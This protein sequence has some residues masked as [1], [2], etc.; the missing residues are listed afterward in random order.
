MG[1]WKR[2]SERTRQTFG[3]KGDSADWKP[4]SNAR[5]EAM[6]EEARKFS[7][8]LKLMHREFK[9]LEAKFSGGLQVIRT[10]LSS[11]LPRVYEMTDKGPVPMQREAMIVGAGVA[12]D[13]LLAAGTDL[14]T[15]LQQ[16]VLH[17]LD[18][19]QAAYRM[20]K[21]RN[22]K[23]EVLRLELDSQRREAAS[24]AV[25][26]DRQ[27]TKVTAHDP[28]K[29]ASQGG[30]GSPNSKFEDA[31]FKLQK[32][33]DKA[34]RLTERYKS[35]EEEVFTALI[36]LIN[37]TQVLKQYA[38]TALIVYQQAFGQAHTAFANA[39]PPVPLVLPTAASAP[40]PPTAQGS[41]TTP[42]KTYPS[43]DQATPDSKA[44]PG[45]P[46]PPGLPTSTA[47]AP[48]AW[49]NEAR[50]QATSMKYDSDDDS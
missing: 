45:T 20:I 38:A 19:W 32:E 26:L 33:E 22:S 35:V 40:V 46:Q 48:P 29:P 37:D 44:S 23:C 42:M 36:T 2:V 12:F 1:L 25:T 16:E 7:K 13:G 3:I 30:A 21:H 8:Q 28:A 50:Q 43:A 34:A 15:K 10:V 24:M 11:P 47:P 5:N 41:E 49:Y 39:T 18:Q 6:L 17:P 27:K 14:K 4:T 31:E 9:E